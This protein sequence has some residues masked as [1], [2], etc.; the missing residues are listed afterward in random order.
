MVRDTCSSVPVVLA[1]TGK[2]PA[3]QFVDCQVHTLTDM[4]QRC[5]RLRNVYE[6]AQHVNLCHAEN[7]SRARRTA[8]GN[9]RADI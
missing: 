8:S 7:F 9:E 3:G 4:N 2:D 6:Y 1:R 5:E